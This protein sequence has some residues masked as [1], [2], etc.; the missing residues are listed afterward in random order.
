MKRIFHWN[1]ENGK[2]DV[3]KVNMVERDQYETHADIRLLAR[4]VR[5]VRS[6]HSPRSLVFLMLLGLYVG[7]VAS[8]QS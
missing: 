5:P 4:M 6:Y 8:A 3:V 1:G 7:V 2:F